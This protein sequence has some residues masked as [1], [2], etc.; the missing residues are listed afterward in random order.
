MFIGIYSL[1]VLFSY[2]AIILSFLACYFMIKDNVQLALIMFLLVGM[3]DVLDGKFASLF[4]RNEFEKRYGVQIDTVIDVFNYAAIPL[5]LLYFM[6]FNQGIDIILFVIYAFCVTSRLA[7]FNTMV[8]E[9]K[10]IFYGVPSTMIVVFLPIMVILYTL[11]NS[12]WVL[13]SLL[14]ITS[15]SFIINIKIKKSRSKKFYGIICLVG[16]LLILGILY[17]L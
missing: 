8:E 3:V 9:E 11:S 10:N 14:L 16:L 17:F 1:W 13:R 15:L 6:G 2:V 4:K 12:M 7:Y 5:V